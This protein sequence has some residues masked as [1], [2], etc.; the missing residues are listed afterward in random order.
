MAARAGL[1]LPAA[2]APPR[3]RVGRSGGPRGSRFPAGGAPSRA[4]ARRSGRERRGGAWCAQRGGWSQPAAGA[5]QRPARRAALWPRG[6]VCSPVS[7]ARAPPA[8]HSQGRWLPYAGPAV[9][10]AAWC[11]SP[12]ENS[13]NFPRGDDARAERGGRR[14]PGRD[15]AARAPAAW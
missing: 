11:A 8:P 7:A 15:G 10:P 1:Q 4:E 13:A 9:T 6:F 2:P 5:S 14:P 12:T 3:G